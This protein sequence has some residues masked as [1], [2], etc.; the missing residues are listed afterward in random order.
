MERP[1]DR[2]AQFRRFR[3]FLANIIFPILFLFL[4]RCNSYPESLNWLFFPFPTAVRAFIHI[5]RQNTLVLSSPLVDSHQIAP[6]YAARC[7]RQLIPSVFCVCHL[8]KRLTHVELEGNHHRGEV[9]HCCLINFFCSRPIFQHYLGTFL[10][11][12]HSLSYHIIW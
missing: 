7:S 11:M 10:S 4:P 8:P 5:A 6:T 2:L 12:F 1:P 3:L 9:T